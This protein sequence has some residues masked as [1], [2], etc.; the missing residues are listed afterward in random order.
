MIKIYNR[1]IIMQSLF[2]YIDTLKTISSLCIKI[3]LFK[4]VGPSQ[5]KTVSHTTRKIIVK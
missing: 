3:K 2:C 1:E 5:K 4:Q